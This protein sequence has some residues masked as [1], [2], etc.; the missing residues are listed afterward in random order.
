M[1]NNLKIKLKSVKIYKKQFRLKI[2]LLKL[3]KEILPSLINY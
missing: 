3:K 1:K 2:N